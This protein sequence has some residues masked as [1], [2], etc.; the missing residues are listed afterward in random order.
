MCDCNDLSRIE[1]SMTKKSATR[2]AGFIESMECLP[3]TKI[4]EGPEW[5]YEI[6]LD[7]YH[8][9]VVRSGGETTLYSRRKNVLNRKF[10]YVAKALD[11]L[12][13]D[14]VLDG[15][16]VAMGPDGKPNFNLL[17]TSGRPNLTSRIMP[18]MC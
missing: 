11:Y 4:P 12:P 10:H 8:L 3:V 1:A 16:L 15:E 17:Q 14:T 18:S 2:A 13:K 7:G 6:K 5:T 9:E